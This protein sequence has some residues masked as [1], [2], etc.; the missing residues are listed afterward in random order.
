M[1]F[2]IATAISDPPPPPQ[3]TMSLPDIITVEGMKDKKQIKT[4]IGVGSVVKA[5]VVDME[6]E[7]RE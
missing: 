4:D 2:L 3:S 7:T 1:L 6:E 5:E